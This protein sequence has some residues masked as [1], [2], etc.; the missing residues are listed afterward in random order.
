[1]NMDNE[2]LTIYPMS[3]RNWELTNRPVN[4]TVVAET[5]E[6]ILLYD[7]GYG[8]IRLID[9]TEDIPVET[10][11]QGRLELIKAGKFIAEFKSH[12]GRIKV[13]KNHKIHTFMMDYYGTS[14]WHTFFA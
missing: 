13:Y 9:L 8:F 11:G 10:T 5:E 14:Y 4:W 6:Y 12:E 3:L 2:I 7:M 1:M